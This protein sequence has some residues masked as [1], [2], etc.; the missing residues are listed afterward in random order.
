MSE[1][2]FEHRIRALHKFEYLKLLADNNRLMILRHLMA[3]PATLSQ[4]SKLLSTYPARLRHHVKLLEEAGLVALTNTRVGQG[5]VEKFYQ[6]TARAFVVNLTLLPVSLPIGAIVVWG[7]DDLALERLAAHLHEMDGMPDLFTLPVGSLDGLIALRQGLCQL[8]GCHLLDAE[9]GEYNSA[10][11]R[12]LFPGQEMLLVTLAYRQQG[13][14]V[15]PGNPLAVHS[16]ADLT[17]EDVRFA[18]RLR[19]AG[20]RVWLD[21][22]LRQLEISPLEI[23]GY[24]T[25]WRTHL[26]VAEAVAT[27]QADVG[28][29]VKA[30]V[31]PFQL[32]FIP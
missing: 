5:F 15:A 4:L 13:L 12:R 2:P 31:R 6:A 27:G 23:R 21:L 7:S 22:Q 30:A 26:Q 9:T 8:A 32:D 11:V 17:R 16:L 1:L 3:G 14:M 20:T 25:A 29:G 10:H 18:N 19:G 28:L 24:E